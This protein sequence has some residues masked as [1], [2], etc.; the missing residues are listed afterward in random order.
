[1]ELKN[2]WF[3]NVG[4]LAYG[5]DRV[6]GVEDILASSSNPAALIGTIQNLASAAEQQGKAE[7]V[8]SEKRSE[9]K[10]RIQTYIEKN[11]GRRI[12]R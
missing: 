7:L 3:L 1:M 8:F 10:N 2:D 6:C 9:W 12:D 11:F 5:L 4:C